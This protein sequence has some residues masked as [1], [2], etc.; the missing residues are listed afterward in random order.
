MDM[1]GDA[2]IHYN[3]GNAHAKSGNRQAA[4][5]SFAKA[6]EKN[7]QHHQALLNLGSVK[8]LHSEMST[9]RRDFFLVYRVRC[10]GRLNLG[11][12]S[13]TCE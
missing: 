7:P 4:H 3:L 6:V 9:V 12:I 1:D 8:E 10:L 11:S 2:A 5:V 13:L